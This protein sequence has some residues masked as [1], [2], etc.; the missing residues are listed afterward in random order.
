[1]SRFTDLTIQDLQVEIDRMNPI[2]I[3][4]DHELV[5]ADD[6]DM[7]EEGSESLWDEC[8]RQYAEILNRKDLVSSISYDIV[9]SHHSSVRII[10]KENYIKG[11]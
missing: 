6:V 10:T 2:K 11:L 7:T 8:N 5:W 3:Y 4:I 1:M 9:D